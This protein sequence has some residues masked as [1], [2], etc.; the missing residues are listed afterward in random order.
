M[1]SCAIWQHCYYKFTMYKKLWLI[2]LT[3][4]YDSLSNFDNLSV[5]FEKTILLG[6]QFVLTQDLACVW[7]TSHKAFSETVE[8]AF[9]YFYCCL[10]FVVSIHSS[11]PGGF[12]WP[13]GFRRLHSITG[14]EGSTISHDVESST[15]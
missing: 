13:S 4:L 5:L 2:N 7:H 1:H 15:I 11:P 8:K 12:F 6:D 10:V 9:T 3:Y 14:S